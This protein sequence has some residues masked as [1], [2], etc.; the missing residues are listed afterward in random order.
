G[1]LT[2]VKGGLSIASG[3]VRDLNGFAKLA[4]ID[5]TLSVD[6][7]AGLQTASLPALTKVGRDVWVNN[8]AALASVNLKALTSVGLGDYSRSITLATL[9]KL[10]RVDLSQL[11]DTPGHVTVG[12]AGGSVESLELSFSS[13]KIAGGNLSLTSITPTSA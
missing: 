9:P 4:N 1:A 10:T 3:A 8:D 2:T 12:P 11:N 5:G 7:N 13:L 6:G